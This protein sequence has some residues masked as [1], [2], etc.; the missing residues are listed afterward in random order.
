MKEG[1]EKISEQKGEIDDKKGKTLEEISKIVI[2]IE[3]QC[4]IKKPILQSQLKQIK[5]LRKTYQDI[6][7]IY[8]QKKVDYDR[9]MV[10]TENESSSITIEL[11]K[12]REEVYSQ[13][14]K[15]SLLKYKTEVIDAKVQR[16]NEEAEFLKGT[17]TL[18]KE[19]KSN[20]DM[21]TERVLLKHLYLDNH[22]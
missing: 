20:S 1:L 6:E 13:D 11:K 18:S 3:N 12:L 22:T 4:N 7:Q 17:K 9:V 2:E 10:G 21:L 19:H 8:N 5:D 16:L 14:T 15:I